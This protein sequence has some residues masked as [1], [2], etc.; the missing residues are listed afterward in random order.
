MCKLKKF[1]GKKK[2]LE[3]SGACPGVEP[4]TSRT[5][6]ENHTTRPTSRLS[7]LVQT[8]F[9]IILCIQAGMMRVRRNQ[10]NTNPN[11]TPS[12]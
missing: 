8:N 5:R 10:T 9:T 11:R 7:R 3:D 12:S 6:S 4:G 1:S 2:S